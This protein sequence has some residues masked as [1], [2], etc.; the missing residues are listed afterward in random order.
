MIFLLRWLFALLHREYKSNH[1]NSVYAVNN[2]TGKG[3]KVRLDRNG[4]LPNGYS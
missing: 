4:N 3:E 2:K 1:P